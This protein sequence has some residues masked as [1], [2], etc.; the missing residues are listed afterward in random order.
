[1]H[2]HIVRSGLLS[3]PI[4]TCQLLAALFL[5]NKQ[6]NSGA[7]AQPFNFLNVAPAFRALSAN[8]LL[9]PQKIWWRGAFHSQTAFKTN[10]V[11][12]QE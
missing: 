8:A 3:A 9:S 6:I 10:V 1:M 7:G 4:F 5:R 11:F 12:A 2:E